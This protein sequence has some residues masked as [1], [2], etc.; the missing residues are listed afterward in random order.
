DVDVRIVRE[1]LERAVRLRNTDRRSLLPGQRFVAVGDGDDIDKPQTPHRIDVMHADEPGA[2][3]P[4]SDSFHC[5]PSRFVWA[6]ESAVTGCDATAFRRSGACASP[7][8]LSSA[9]RAAR[10]A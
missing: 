1:R 7:A 6:G 4:H 9:P 5:A 3:Q 10:P 8:A 2:D